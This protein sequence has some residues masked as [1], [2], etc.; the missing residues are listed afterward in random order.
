VIDCFKRLAVSGNTKSVGAEQVH[1]VY[2]TSHPPKLLE[3]TEL[4]EVAVELSSPLTG[5][6]GREKGRDWRG[7]RLP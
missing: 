6:L 4:H 2:V 3:M 1:A 5:Y 7:D